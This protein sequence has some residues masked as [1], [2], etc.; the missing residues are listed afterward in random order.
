MKFLPAKCQHSHE[1]P[2]WSWKSFLSYLA[3]IFSFLSED[4]RLCGARWSWV[5]AYNQ[6][7]FYFWQTFSMIL[8][9]TALFPMGPDVA[10]GRGVGTIFPRWNSLCNLSQC[11]QILDFF[12]AQNST[13]QA[14]Y[15]F[16][17]TTMLN[18]R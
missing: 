17:L 10:S 18:F 5:W 6:G 16:S 4:V 14:N 2:G 7:P 9:I 8:M 12:L 11:P 3:F 15:F 13:F 1:L